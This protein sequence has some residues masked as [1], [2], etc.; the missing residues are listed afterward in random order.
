MLRKASRVHSSNAV[1]ATVA[2]G[3]LVAIFVPGWGLGRYWS[4]VEYMSGL[5]SRRD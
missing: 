5:G 4:L 3:K 2:F 1:I